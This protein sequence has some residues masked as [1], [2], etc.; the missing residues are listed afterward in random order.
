[1]TKLHP[2][3]IKDANGKKT[4]VVLSMDE[5]NSLMEGLEELE[6]IKLFD[7]AKKEDNGKRI[8]LSDYLKKR[9]SKNA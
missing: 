6:D 1:M 8:L 5:F 9:K 3:F 7:K 4:L 2:Q